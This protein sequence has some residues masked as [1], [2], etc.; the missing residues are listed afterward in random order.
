M[1]PKLRLFST[2]TATYIELDGKALGPGVERVEI[3]H[4]GAG[5]AR[6]ILSIDVA[7]FSFMPDGFFDE[8]AKRL[9]EANPPND[10]LVRRK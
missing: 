7:N 8:A 10:G 1:K 4:N 9:E 3:T 2:G 6:L 5:E